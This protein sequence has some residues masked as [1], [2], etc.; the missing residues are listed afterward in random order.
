MSVTV[1]K[2]ATGGNF[3]IPSPGQEM[4]VREIW[5]VTWAGDPANPI[6]DAQIVKDAIT[7]GLPYVGKRNDSCDSNFNMLVCQSLDWQKIP[8]CSTAWN[9]TVTWGTYANFVTASNGTSTQPFTRVTRIGSMRMMNAYR[10]GVTPPPP[11]GAGAYSWPPSTDIAGTRIDV[12]GQPSQ[13]GVPQLRIDIE[14]MYDRTS[15]DGG[16]GGEPTNELTAYMGVRNAEPFLG[17][18]KGYVLC[19][20]VAATP[21][22]DQWYLMQYS[23]L[24]DYWAHHEQR[25][26]PN[27]GGLNFLVTAASNFIGVPYKNASKVGWWQPYTDIYDLNDMFPAD[28]LAA[29]TSTAPTVEA[30]SNCLAAPRDLSGMQFNYGAFP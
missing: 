16:I 29:I 1:R 30:G 14:W 11:S 12:N 19:T 4:T 17:F 25:S 7:A 24:F 20:S 28:V 15:T 8:T 9:V 26:A 2:H 21:L 27:L 3:F 23:Y 6:A 5:T 10:T 22:N 18:S 13:F